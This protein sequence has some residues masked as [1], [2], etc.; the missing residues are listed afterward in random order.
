MWGL[1]TLISRMKKISKTQ[2]PLANRFVGSESTMLL[3]KLMTK[4]ELIII[5]AINGN[6]KLLSIFNLIAS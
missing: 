3:K 4:N 6:G 1:A 2:G 5:R